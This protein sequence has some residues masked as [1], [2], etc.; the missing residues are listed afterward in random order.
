MSFIRT[1]FIFLRDNCSGS[2]SMQ[3]NFVK[4]KIDCVFFKILLIIAL[5]TEKIIEKRN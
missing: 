4:E 5:M 1:V 2:F 3:G